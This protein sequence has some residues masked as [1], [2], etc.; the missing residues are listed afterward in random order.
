MSS[1]DIQTLEYY[2]TVCNEES[3]TKAST[4]LHV[5]QPTL[6]RHIAALEEELGVKLLNRSKYRVSVTDAGALMKRR[7]QEMLVS[8]WKTQQELKQLADNLTGELRIGCGEYQ[9][10]DELAKAIAEFYKLYPKVQ[11]ILY[12]TDNAEKLQ[13]LFTGVLDMCLMLEDDNTEQE[14]IIM[15]GE[16]E[17]GVLVRKEHPLA[18]HN[19]ISLEMLKNYPEVSVSADIVEIVKK[20]ANVDWSQLKGASHNMLFNTILTS[21]NMEIPIVCAKVDYE[22]TDLKF[23]RFSP[24]IKAKTKLIW[25]DHKM[26]PRLLDTFIAYL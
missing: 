14:C 8:Y 21:K 9:V 25:Q 5:S 15:P 22:S 4:I 23:I 20:K 11:I 19:V 26:V 6:S 17:L 24:R 7:T 1:M 12:H 3:I 16:E 2:V 10:V 13:G 18:M